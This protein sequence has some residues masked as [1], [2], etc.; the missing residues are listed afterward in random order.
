M[1][2]AQLSV[3]SVAVVS[4]AAVASGPAASA[5]VC[6]GATSPE[7]CATTASVVSTAG[8]DD[9]AAARPASV[10]PA[11]GPEGPRPRRGRR[12]PPRRRWRR[13]PGPP[14]GGA[15]GAG[16][17]LGPLGPLA[18]LLA[19]G[20]ALQGLALGARAA[21]VTLVDPHLH[22]DAAEGRAGLVDAV[23][24]V[25]AQRVQ[26]H[27]P[28]A[29]ELRPAHLGAAQATGA[30][31]PDALDLRAALG[32]LHGLAHRAAEADP[33]GQLLGHALGNQLR[34]GLGVLD[35]EDVQLHLLAGELLQLTADAVGL[36]A[37]AADDDARPGGVDV[38]ADAVAGALDLDLR[39]PGPLHPL[40]HEL[41]D[42]HVFLDVVLVQL[43]GVPPGLVVGGDA[44]P[45][46]VRVDLLT[47][48]R[49]PPLVL[50]FCWTAGPDWPVSRRALRDFCASS[51]LAATSLTSTVMWLVRLLM[52]NA[53]PWARGRIRLSVGPSST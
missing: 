14:G 7:V 25:G 24:D 12:G 40:A 13:A 35:L 18:T 27:A 50:L 39:D 3:F 53:R 46:P 17:A 33:A 34:V 16:A 15:G 48:Y 8:P 4:A 6:S 2:M 21:D 23:V 9:S 20:G 22:A 32:R 36:G 1:S 37:T 11:G 29:V 52:R 47:H 43:V 26:R 49:V 45:E 10:P 44:E 42:G 31:H 51:A 41:A 5:T 30:L 19:L 38:D 28:L